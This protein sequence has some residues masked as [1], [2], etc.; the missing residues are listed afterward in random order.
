[1]SDCKAMASPRGTAHITG[2]RQLMEITIDE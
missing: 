2:K 1:M